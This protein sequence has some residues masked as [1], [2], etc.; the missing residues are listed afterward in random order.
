[1]LGVALLSD[2]NE[3]L[4]LFGNAEFHLRM[5]KETSESSFANRR[6]TSGISSS[7]SLEWHVDD[8]VSADADKRPLTR[9]IGNISS[10]YRVS[11]IP[12]AVSAGWEESGGVI[13]WHTTHVD[14]I[15]FRR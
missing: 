9:D 13:P 11:K 6:S 12:A 10:S 14:V 5:G 15:T 4:H 2:S 7:S 8:K 3:I 1:M